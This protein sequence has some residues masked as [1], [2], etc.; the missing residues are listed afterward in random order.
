M[1]ENIDRSSRESGTAT[2]MSTEM[3]PVD[4]MEENDDDWVWAGSRKA[5]LDV[6][7]A[8]LAFQ[9]SS[10]NGC[11]ELSCLLPSGV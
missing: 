2:C 5:A 7:L 3:L 4:N 11:D 1:E 6:W 9:L 10:G 8:Y